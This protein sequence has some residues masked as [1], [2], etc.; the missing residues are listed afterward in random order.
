MSEMLVRNIQFLILFSYM[1]IVAKSMNNFLLSHYSNRLIYRCSIIMMG[2]WLL[3]VFSKLICMNF[4]SLNDG[5]P[6]V[7]DAAFSALAAIAKV[8]ISRFSIYISL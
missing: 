4:Q 7:R 8:I 5:T 2:H 6:D 3:F 1:Y